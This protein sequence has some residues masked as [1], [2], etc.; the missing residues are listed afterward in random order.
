ME[1]A[2][3]QPRR[4]ADNECEVSRFLVDALNQQRASVLPDDARITVKQAREAMT[5]YMLSSSNP[6][7]LLPECAL[8]AMQARMAAN[9]EKHGTD[10]WKKRDSEYYLDHAHTHM[11]R[12]DNGDPDDDHL[13]AIACDAMLA[14]ACREVAQ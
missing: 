1:K 14:L 12:H 4:C 6:F 3:K 13:C 2:K 5:E 7:P 10:G 11:M 8:A 9:V